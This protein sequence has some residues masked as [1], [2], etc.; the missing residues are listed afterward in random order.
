M[1]ERWSI[2]S[3]IGP[4]PASIAGFEGLGP[5]HAQR[6]REWDGVEVLAVATD[7]GLDLIARADQAEVL[8]TELLGR[9]AP[10]RSARRRPR[11]SESSRAGR[12]S[13]TS[14]A[15]A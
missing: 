10:S 5:E 2:A 1:S 6:F 12:A 8:R 13:G 7:T 14:S 15:S 3:L 11:S 4:A 9:R